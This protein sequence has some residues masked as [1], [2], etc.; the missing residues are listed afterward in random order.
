MH[1][2]TH[3]RTHTRTHSGSNVLNLKDRS[4]C[5]ENSLFHTEQL[6]FEKV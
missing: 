2:H 4:S 6:H 3:A 1:L 5:L